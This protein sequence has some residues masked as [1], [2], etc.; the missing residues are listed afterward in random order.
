MQADD[1]NRCPRSDNFARK[2]YIGTC[3]NILSMEW[4]VHWNQPISNIHQKAES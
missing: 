2:I 4:T 3:H 1:L